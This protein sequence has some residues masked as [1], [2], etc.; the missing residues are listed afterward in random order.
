MIGLNTKVMD[1][2]DE[3]E[4]VDYDDESSI[5]LVIMSQSE[6]QQYRS[7]VKNLRKKMI[8]PD[9]ELYVGPRLARTESAVFMVD[10]ASSLFVVSSS[11][12]GS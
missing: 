2:E 9:L 4:W 6:T 10:T 7:I 1:D 8:Q 5:L 3:V 11:S 12:A